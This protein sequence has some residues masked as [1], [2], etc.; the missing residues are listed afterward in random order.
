MTETMNDQ[1]LERTNLLTSP[2]PSVH[3]ISGRE[4]LLANTTPYDFEAISEIE[5]V[6]N[7]RVRWLSNF[8]NQT[9]EPIDKIGGALFET[10][11]GG[12]LG[13]ALATVLRAMHDTVTWTVRE[14]AIL[15][16]FVDAD[17]P[18]ETFEQVSSLALEN[19]DDVVGKLARKYRIAATM[20]GAL[21]GATGFAG[22]LADIPLVLSIALRGITE[23]AAY[24]GFYPFN[25]AEKRYALELLSAA[26][27]PTLKSR[28]ESLALLDDRAPHWSSGSDKDAVFAAQVVERLLEGILSR[29]ARGKVAQTIPLVGALIGGGFNRWF[30]AQVMSLAEALYRERFLMRAYDPLLRVE[31]KSFNALA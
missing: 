26:A 30:V 3:E 27:S 8:A 10:E 24:Y 11:V 19:V 17:H 31:V 12:W 28:Q 2:T 22:M 6:K 16:K 4:M 5:E 7:P 23:F 18:I 9:H 29:M 13:G 15:Q 14:D 25:E 21:V 1:R 20:E